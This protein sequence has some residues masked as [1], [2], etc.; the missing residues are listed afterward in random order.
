[1]KQNEGTT[2]RLMRVLI[3]FGILPLAFLGPQTPWAYLGLIPLV[4]GLTGI[5]PLYSVLGI[6]TCPLKK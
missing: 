3:G 4:T 6:T 1:M 5:C 2:D